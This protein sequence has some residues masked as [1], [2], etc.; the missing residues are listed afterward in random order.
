MTETRRERFVRAAWAPVDASSIAAFR[1]M[2]G[3]ALFVGIVR[4][5]L[6]GWVDV[7]FVQP[8]FFFKYP[9]LEWVAVP[10]AAVLYA[11]YAALAV[12]ALALAAGWN[13]RVTAALF[14]LGFAYAEAMDVTNY[15]NHYYLVVLLGALFAVL[16]V[17]RA[18]GA[19]PVWVLWLFRFQIAVVY[20]HAGL[21]KAGSDWLLHA[22]PLG[23]WMA[24]RTETP[25]IGPFLHHAW[26]AFAMSWA[27]FL[28]DT[29]IVGW[30]SWRRT[31]AIAFAFVLAFHGLTS[32]FFEIGMF[33]ILMPI[34]ATLFFAPDWPARLL[35]LRPRAA[36][37]PMALPSGRRRAVI[38][39]ALACWCSFH[40]LFPL[41]HLAHPGDVLWNE[42][43]MRWA[44]KVM[45]REKS[46][47]ITYRVRN[48]ETGRE[49]QVTPH[50]Y[51]TWRQANEMSGQPD[52][53]AQLARHIAADFERRGLGAVEVR[54]DAWVSLNGRSSAR[55]IDPDADLAR[56]AIPAGWILDGPETPP[57]IAGGRSGGPR[58]SASAAAREPRE[59]RP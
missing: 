14:T 43:G 49:W 58:S 33:P 48:P 20:F 3:L 35:R 29:T 21:A 24:A 22:Q 8:A 9:G 36:R 31:R 13:V 51:L 42:E 5:V 27:G 52:L 40:A 54:A 6:S 18:G 45:V 16:P 34:A 46:G 53:I 37:P 44:W 59:A 57:L 11:L 17:A 28:F 4:F 32:V 41:R 47:S 12:L 55:M 25:V 50:R 56:E 2:F 7:L 15:L 23:I 39:V 26:T 30:L 19:V 38:A 10:P 1:A